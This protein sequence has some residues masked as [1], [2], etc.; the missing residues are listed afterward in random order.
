M[1]DQRAEY[2]R[3]LEP[4]RRDRRR[5][6]GPGSKDDPPEL[7]GARKR[8]VRAGYSLKGHSRTLASTM[9]QINGSD[10]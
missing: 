7:S 1:S 2:F 10:R 6:A 3:G 9:H 5:G 8:S 4:D